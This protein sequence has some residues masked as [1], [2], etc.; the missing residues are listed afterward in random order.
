LQAYEDEK[1]KNANLT[2][3]LTGDKQEMM[4]SKSR[5]NPVIVVKE[6]EEREA[7]MK[8]REMEREKQLL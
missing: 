7:E 4:N 8:L 5:D 2:D 3:M 6:L 1:A